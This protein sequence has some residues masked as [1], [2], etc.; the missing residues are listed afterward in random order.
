MREIK[1]RGK[2]VN[3]KQFVPERQWVTGSLIIVGP[4]CYIL[5]ID[6]PV[7]LKWLSFNIDEFPADL[8]IE[9]IPETVGQ[10]TGLLDKNGKEIYE[11]DMVRFYYSVFRGACCGHH[12]DINKDDY[13]EIIDEVIFKDGAFYFWW[14]EGERGALAWQYND[15]C[16]VIGDVHNNP[17]LLKSGRAK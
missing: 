10:F 6:S 2:R 15:V 14:R 9:V 7:F 4:K 8:L 3:Y 1:F 11:G 12:E 17:E 16:E 5:P 13:T